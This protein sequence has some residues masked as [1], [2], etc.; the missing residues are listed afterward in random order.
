MKAI[1]AAAHHWPDTG[2]RI[3][4]EKVLLDPRAVLPEEESITLDSYVAKRVA[5]QLLTPP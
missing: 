3:E 5:G 2:Y 4:D 1:P